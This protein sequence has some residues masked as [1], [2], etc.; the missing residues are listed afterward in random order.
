MQQII[1]TDFSGV[2]G[3][4]IETIAESHLTPLS[5]KV[6]TK[7]IPV[8]PY[9]WMT[10]Y[11]LLKTIRPVKLPMVIG[12]GFGGIVES[13]G[14]LRDHQL[15]GKAVIGVQPTGSA[16]TVINAQ[17]P[18]LLFEV[19]PKVALKD[20]VTLIGGADAAL[21][22]VNSIKANSTDVVLVTG[23]SGGVGTYLIQLLKLA[24]ATVIALANP[25]NRV[26]VQSLGADVV[27]NYQA[28]LAAQLT[29]TVVP[30]KVIDA[31]GRPELLQTIT[32]VYEQL[33]IFSLS[34]TNFNPPKPNQSFKF[35]HGSIGISGYHQLL[36]LLATGQIQAQI[37]TVYPFE[38]VKKAHLAAKNG[39]ARGRMLLAF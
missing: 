25:D 23:A 8:L 31:V 4:Q 6:N 34:L 15:V 27:L 18:P 1:Q 33:T 7:Y 19:P 11:G 39:H 13:T 37:Q 36:A 17:L 38:D 3:L 5:V 14:L 28:D 20:A 22:A 30:N 24:G 26:F 16:Q 10:E 21:H 32:T 35:S 2:D 29:R 12:Y 9:D